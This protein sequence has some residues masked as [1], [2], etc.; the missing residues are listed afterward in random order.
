MAPTFK[1][2]ADHAVL[3]SF[4]T[5]ISDAAI[6]RV[7]AFDKAIAQAHLKGVCESVPAFVNILVRFDPIVTDHQELEMALRG[8]L[9]TVKTATETVGHKIVHVCYDAAFGPDISNVAQGC[10]LSE[11]AVINAHLAGDYHVVM[12]GFAPGYAY[13]GGVPE[14]IQVP[15]K[16]SPVRD[17]PAGSVIIASAQCLVSTIVMPTGWSI[18]GRSPTKI[19]LDQSDQPFLFDVGDKVTFKRIGLTTYEQMSKEAQNG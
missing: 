8:I 6:Q 19:L 5:E 13:M 2:V 7:V 3:V 9:E 15:R 17:V 4:A 1:P 18:I 16:P 14:V 12:Y 11:E 10:N